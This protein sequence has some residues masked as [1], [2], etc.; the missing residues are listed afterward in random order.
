MVSG[1]RKSCAWKILLHC[2]SAYML[3]VTFWRVQFS[4]GFFDNFFPQWIKLDR[5]MSQMDVLVK[6]LSPYPLCR[7]TPLSSHMSSCHFRAQLVQHWLLGKEGFFVIIK[8]QY[9]Y[10]LNPLPPRSETWAIWFYC[11]MP[12]DFS[13][14]LGPNLGVNGLEVQ[15]ISSLV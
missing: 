1:R 5:K 14:Q 7:S 4:C 3:K 6:Y 15:F 13:R 11:L 8:L 10:P 9:V 2:M 12:G